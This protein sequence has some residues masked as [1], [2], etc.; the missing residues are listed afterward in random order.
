MCLVIEPGQ[1]KCDNIFRFQFTN[2]TIGYPRSILKF[3]KPLYFVSTQ[4]DAHYRWK[5]KSLS[6]SP[7]FHSCKYGYPTRVHQCNH[8]IRLKGKGLITD[9]CGNAKKSI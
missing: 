9:L 5:S 3:I 2:E 1:E 8:Y 6:S 7:Q 4:V